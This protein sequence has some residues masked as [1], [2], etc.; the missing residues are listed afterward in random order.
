MGSHTEGAVEGVKAAGRFLR[1]KAPVVG[2]A[3]RYGLMGQTA[4]S[5]ASGAA[6]LIG[7][8]AQSDGN[9]FQKIGT[10]FGDTDIDSIR[11]VA[12]LGAISS[13]G[14]LNKRNS[15][16]FLR[17]TE[18]I[19]GKDAVNAVKVGDKTYDLSK[20]FKGQN[21][22]LFTLFRR[23]DNSKLSKGQLNT[24][25]KELKESLKDDDVQ[26]IMDAVK[27]DGIG[28]IKNVSTA[29]EN[30][31]RVLKEGPGMGYKNVRDY[32]IAKKMIERGSVQQGSFRHIYNKLS[33]RS[34]TPKDINAEKTAITEANAETLKKA[35]SALGKRGSAARAAAIKKFY[36]KNVKVKNLGKK[37]KPSQFNKQGGVLKMK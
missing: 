35:S 10:G 3:A 1:E 19:V 26:A 23:V 32:N 4:I 14:Y 7:N 29:A 2:T 13:I 21:S 34:Y 15:N 12:Q 11:R 25:E 17:N 37:V 9:I 31:R 22:S 24:L 27:K 28:A 16:A 8:I 30:V 36:G 20:S 33:G 6:D 18:E 5:G